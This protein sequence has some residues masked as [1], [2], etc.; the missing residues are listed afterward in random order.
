[1]TASFK[2]ANKKWLAKFETEIGKCL[3]DTAV[4]ELKAGCVALVNQL[5]Q[6]YAKIQALLD[7]EKRKDTSTH[8][9]V[10]ESVLV[11]VV[12]NYESFAKET[13]LKAMEKLI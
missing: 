3:G 1:M 10:L 6:G 13:C 12:G 7:D 2:I 11:V 4:R 9:M 8:I 5:N